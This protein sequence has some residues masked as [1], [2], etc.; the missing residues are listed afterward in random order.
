M[1]K[2]AIFTAISSVMISC[3]SCGAQD[4]VETAEQASDSNDLTQN[5]GALL[6]LFTEGASTVPTFSALYTPAEN[7]VAVLAAAKIKTRLYPAG[8]V[9]TDVTDNKVVAHLNNCTGRFGLLHLTGDVTVVFTI[10]TDGIHAAATATG[11]KVN[12]ATMDIQ[13]AAV[14]TVNGNVITIAVKTN[15]TGTGPRGNAIT[16]NGNFTVTY[17]L[18]DECR[19][20]NGAWSTVVGSATWSTTISGLERC[21]TDCP[22]SGGT[23]VHTN[24][25]GKTLTV[26]FDGSNSAAWSYSGGRSGTVTMY[27]GSNS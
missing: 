11:L 12:R 4:I 21:G 17:D 13:S 26:A 8:C 14:R 2:A 9:T 18:S 6:A 10:E 5:E 25:A 19:T 7:Q 1:R 27:C 20:L 22:K 16:R 24:G 23:L 15:G 3:L